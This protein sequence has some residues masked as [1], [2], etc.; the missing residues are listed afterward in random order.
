[1]PSA[2]NGYIAS[3]NSSEEN[4]NNQENTTWKRTGFQ[5]VNFIIE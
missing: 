3:S 4:L 2:R 5:T 1:M